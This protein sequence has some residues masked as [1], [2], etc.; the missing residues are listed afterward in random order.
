LFGSSNSLAVTDGVHVDLTEGEALAEALFA[1]S[2]SAS[3]LSTFTIRRIAEEKKMKPILS[4]YLDNDYFTQSDTTQRRGA[5]FDILHCNDM[6]WKHV[7]MTICQKGFVGYELYPMLSKRFSLCIKSPTLSTAQG[8][9]KTDLNLGKEKQK[10]CFLP[11]IYEDREMKIIEEI[12]RKN[13]F[14]ELQAKF[15]NRDASSLI[16]FTR[17]GV[18]EM[19]FRAGKAMDGAGVMVNAMISIAKNEAESASAYDE[20]YP[21]ESLEPMDDDA[22]E[23]EENEDVDDDEE[24]SETDN[25]HRNHMASLVVS[26]MVPILPPYMSIYKYDVQ[27]T[28]FNAAPDAGKGHSNFK[29][30]GKTDDWVL[31]KERDEHL[32]PT[33]SQNLDLILKNAKIPLSSR[34]SFFKTAINLERRLDLSF[35]TS[36]LKSAHDKSA[37]GTNDLRMQ[38]AHW[39]GFDDLTEEDFVFIETVFPLLVE[40]YRTRGF[41]V[42]IAWKQIMGNF[43]YMKNIEALSETAI[44]FLALKE[45]RT[46]GENLHVTNYGPAILNHPEFQ[47]REKEKL[48]DKIAKIAELNNERERKTRDAELLANAAAVVK[49]DKELKKKLAEDEMEEVAL[50]VYEIFQDNYFAYERRTDKEGGLESFSK[51]TW[52]KTNLSDLRKTYFIYIRRNQES[53]TSGF[54]HPTKKQEFLDAL[55]NCFIDMHTAYR[56]HDV[57]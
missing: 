55:Q 15:S 52:K 32:C 48:D 20:N 1:P 56:T 11:T 28:A 23:T 5:S 40:I 12:R 7:I 35:S 46:P 3:R 13:M 34:R 18:N 4:N 26:D 30:F 21:S 53:T 27:S 44:K 38:I 43:I 57:V 41:C 39:S 29:K 19:H 14:H 16:P 8:T 31:K 51:W 17:E 37:F 54:V 33:Y 50:S 25:P 45:M 49:F 10:L 36:V 9:L 42:E 2:S 22:P 47:R 6:C 24:E